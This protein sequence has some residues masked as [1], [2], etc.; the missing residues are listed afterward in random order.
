MTSPE[1][2]PKP[3]ARIMLSVRVAPL[4]VEKF[5]RAAKRRGLTQSDAIREALADWTRRNS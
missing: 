3:P 5:R 2:P 1:Q 4:G